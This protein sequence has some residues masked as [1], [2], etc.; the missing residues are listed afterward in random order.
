MELVFKECSE[1]Y[2]EPKLK[3]VISCPVCYY[4]Y[5]H[6]SLMTSCQK[7]AVVLF[8]YQWYN[9][10]GV[11]LYLCPITSCLSMTTYSVCQGVEG[12]DWMQMVQYNVL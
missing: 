6:P 11:G 9:L 2:W 12:M 3:L 5:I 1:R 8:F 7:P 4:L 10:Y